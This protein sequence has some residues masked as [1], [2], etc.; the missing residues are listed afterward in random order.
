MTFTRRE[1]VVASAVVASAGCAKV[2]DTGSANEGSIVSFDAFSDEF[3]DVVDVSSGSATLG[4]GF[5]WAE[6][7]AWDHTRQ[8]LY[9]TDVPENRAYR[10]TELAG[11]ELFLSPSGVAPE[12]AQGMREPGA[13]GLLMSQ[14]GRLILCNHGKRAVEKMNIDNGVRETLVDRFEGARFN[15]PNDIIE[16][17][18]GTLYFTDPP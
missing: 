11:L 3:G 2:G 5:R 14:D 12:L 16:S 1:F 6:G 7:P 13:N 10:W 15:S 18:D 8:A 4:R 17:K 9:F